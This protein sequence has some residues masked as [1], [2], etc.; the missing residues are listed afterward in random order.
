[1][2]ERSI[3][4]LLSEE[5]ISLVGGEIKKFMEDM[6]FCPMCEITHENNT[7]CQ[8]NDFYV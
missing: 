1:M 5:K 3:V 7:N 4:Q 8:R 6:V 2:F